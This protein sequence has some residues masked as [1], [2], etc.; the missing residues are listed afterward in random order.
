MDYI[1]IMTVKGIYSG[2]TSVMMLM[3]SVLAL[4]VGAAA[5]RIFSS[6]IMY[7]GSDG[8]IVYKGTNMYEYETVVCSVRRSCWIMYCGSIAC[9]QT[10]E[11]ILYEDSK[12]TMLQLTSGLAGS[13]K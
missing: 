11:Q 2:R 3:K 4:D 1:N 5:R 6:G 13:Q 12:D 9:K 8:S 10:R 7:F